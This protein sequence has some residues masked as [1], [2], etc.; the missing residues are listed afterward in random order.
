MWPRF[1]PA[2]TPPEPGPAIVPG[3]DRL[4]IEQSD[5][6]K[7]VFDIKAD[8]VGLCFYDEDN[9]PVTDTIFIG[10]ADLEKAAEVLSAARVRIA[11]RGYR[12]E[13]ATGASLEAIA[14]DMGAQ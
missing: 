11:S 2:F 13:T 6:H 12:L 10:A 4:V 7:L 14:K 8:V 5:G 9:H 3:P 1:K